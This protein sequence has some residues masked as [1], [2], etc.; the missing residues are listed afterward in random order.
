MSR[1]A[2]AG[3]MLGLRAGRRAALRGVGAAGGRRI[4]SWTDLDPAAIS[5]S[6]PAQAYNLGSRRLLPTGSRT[7]CLAGS[8]RLEA[9]MCMYVQAVKMVKLFNQ[10]H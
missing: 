8:R 10:Q 2:V 5:G 4:A 3:A 6:R 1:T 9:G 7:T